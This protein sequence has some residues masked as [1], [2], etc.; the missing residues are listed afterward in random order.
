MLNREIRS[1]DNM[2]D[3]LTRGNQLLK[4]EDLL[5]M[6]ENVFYDLRTNYPE[7]NTIPVGT[8]A[9][10]EGLFD[11]MLERHRTLRLLAIEYVQSK[12][13]SN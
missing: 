1:P 9:D 7:F 11:L 12:K 4:Y 2:T 3:R 8:K 6:L 10:A 13:G 5:R